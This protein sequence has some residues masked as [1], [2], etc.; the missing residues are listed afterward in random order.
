MEKFKIDR[1]EEIC[2][3]INVNKFIRYAKLHRGKVD[4]YLYKDYLKFAS[5]LGYDLKSNKYAFQK[6]LRK[7]HDKLA[8][9]YKIHNKELLDKTISRRY[10]KLE[11]NVFKNKNF[12]IT[13]SPTIAALEDES[14]QQH[15]CVRTYAED[16][17][18]EICDI[19]FMR[20]IKAQDKSLVTV[21]VKD[22]KVVQS[23]IKYNDSPNKTQIQFL[24]NWE[25]KVL[26][27]AA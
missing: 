10:K 25:R 12:I 1:L 24:D 19:Y 4:T 14:K 27:G 11:K 18:S 16:Y 9:Q 22:N 17:A 23:R 20:D 26:K 15:N 6:E 21:E 2:M 3:Y 5:V 13:P 7:E 8:I